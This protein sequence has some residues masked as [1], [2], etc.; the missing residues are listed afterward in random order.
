[1]LHNCFLFTA[2][3]DTPFLSCMCACVMNGAVHI[4]VIN[5]HSP[6]FHRE[7]DVDNSETVYHT[8]I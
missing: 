5:L 6:Y 3:R 4:S 8:K 1:M 7:F 2:I